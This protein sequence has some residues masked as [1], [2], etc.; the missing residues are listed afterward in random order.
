MVATAFGVAT[1][2]RLRSEEAELRAE[3]VLATGVSRLRW[4]GA[5]LAV[6]FGGPVALLVV[7]GLGAG[8]GHALRT[9]DAS[10]VGRLAGAALA[11]APA[12]WVVVGAAAL[13]FGAVP[14]R[15][16][17]AWAVY[18]AFVLIAEIGPLLEL[19]SWFED[20]SP[21]TH[22][23]QLPGHAVEALP[24]A[25]LS[26]TAVALTTAALAALRRRDIG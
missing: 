7:A 25:A 12:V 18:A 15:L 19:G 3:P 5:H 16:A 20:L 22:A 2:M 21:F 26:A 24:L 8:A 4:A 13:L 17:V 10:Q 1:V 14:R 23:P 9:H 11:Q 6:A